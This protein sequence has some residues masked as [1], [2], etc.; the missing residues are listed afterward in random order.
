MENRTGA[1]VVQIAETRWN[2]IYL[3]KTEEKAKEYYN[4]LLQH[5]VKR[6]DYFHQAFIDQ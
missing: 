5:G 1:Y 6:V 4:Y 3:F 2:E